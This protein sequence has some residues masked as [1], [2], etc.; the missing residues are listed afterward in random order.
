MK[1]KVVEDRNIAFAGFVRNAIH[2]SIYDWIRKWQ[3]GP[4]K[5]MPEKLLREIPLLSNFYLTFEDDPSRDVQKWSEKSLLLIKQLKKIHDNE[6]T[7]YRKEIKT[8]SKTHEKIIKKYGNFLLRVIPQITKIK[9]QYSEIFI[10]P[11]VYYG[12]TTEDNKI[13][14][15]VVGKTFKE[16]TNV[17]R[18]LPG[19]I[20]E[21][22]H[23]NT[24][25]KFLSRYSKKKLS[26]FVMHEKSQFK[27]PNATIEIATMLTANQ[28]IK[29]AEQNFGIK[30]EMQKTHPHYTKLIT[31]IE[32]DFDSFESTKGFYSMRK[33]IDKLIEK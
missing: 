3:K 6:W 11:S 28:V 30:L 24:L 27:N 33:T 32:K 8:F 1:L 16:L 23:V 5:K 2:Y 26:E 18:R 9:W 22:I 10:I 29:L 31:K 13:F 17:E 4:L 12:A 25:P 20:H 7:R 14:R 15:G 21:L 19:L